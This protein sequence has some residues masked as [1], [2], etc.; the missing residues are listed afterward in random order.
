MLWHKIIGKFI[1]HRKYNLHRISKNEILF[2]EI[3]DTNINSSDFH[4]FQKEWIEKWNPKINEENVVER[5][6]DH[7]L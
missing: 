4:D 2:E 6:L 1:D 3:I 7:I 5:Y